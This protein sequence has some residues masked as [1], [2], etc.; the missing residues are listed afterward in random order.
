MMLKNFYVAMCFGFEITWR[1]K[2]FF[3][4]SFIEKSVV[5]LFIFQS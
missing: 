5:K 1:H 2:R 3:S 4:V